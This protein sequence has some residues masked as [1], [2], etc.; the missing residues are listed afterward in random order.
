MATTAASSFTRSVSVTPGGTLS[1]ERWMLSFK[2]NPEMSTSMNSG[3]SFGR[4]ETS[5][6]VRMRHDSPL[7]FDARRHR[8][9]G[10]M[11]RNADAN[12]LVFLDALKIDVHDGILERVP[13]HVLQDG[14]LRLI[15]HLQTEDG[16]IEALVV[17]HDQ[18]LL[19]AQSQG[20]RVGVPA[21]QNCRYF[22]FV[23]QAAARTFALRLAELGDE[24]ERGFHNL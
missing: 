4:H 7:R 19:V 11:Q 22:S 13:L 15:A 17:E 1:C 2:D 21:I 18:E 24:F 12:L 23:T 6:S 16:R 3:K 20:A 5:V 9:P 14:R 10:E 8:S